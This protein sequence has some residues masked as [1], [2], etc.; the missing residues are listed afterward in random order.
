MA[1]AQITHFRELMAAQQFGQIYSEAADELKRSTT[2]QA[3][4]NLLS[5]VERKLG[6]V[7][8]AEKNGWSVNYQ[9]SG[10]TVT[11]KYKT[12]FERGSGLETFVYRIA[13]DKAL[14]AGYHINS[15][16]LITN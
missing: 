15:T 10:T 13:G 3:M 12:Q 11:L 1:E 6:P 16:D 5:A 4:V 2:D 7:K 9:T 14:L 8:S